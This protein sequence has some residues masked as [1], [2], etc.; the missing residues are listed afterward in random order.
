MN[1]DAYRSYHAVNLEARTAQASPVQLVL[2]LMD[3]LLEELARARAHIQAR[4]IELK[5]RSLDK[6]IDIL[7]GLSSALD[8][9]AGGEVVNNLG[10]LYDHCAHRLYQAGFELDATLVD[11]VV[12]LLTTLRSGW[13]GVEA[14]RG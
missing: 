2:I 7:N 8:T 13:Q 6:C 4:R 14:Q 11:E 5:A 1:H 3:G 9:D 12:K 10:R